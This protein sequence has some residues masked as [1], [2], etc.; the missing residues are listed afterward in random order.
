VVSAASAY[1]SSPCTSEIPEKKMIKT[2]GLSISLEPALAS[3]G[4]SD[5]RISKLSFHLR[6]TDKVFEM[7]IGISLGG[8]ISNFDVT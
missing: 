1:R 2:K 7:E 3:G 8:D 4:I 5:F 6:D